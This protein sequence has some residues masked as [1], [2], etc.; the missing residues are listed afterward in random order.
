MSD[1]DRA[2]EYC[3]KI[4]ARVDNWARGEGY[5]P[6]AWGIEAA[7]RDAIF[8]LHHVADLEDE[9]AD[10]TVEAQQKAAWEGLHHALLKEIEAN[11]PRKIQTFGEGFKVGTIVIDSDGDAWQV[12]K[13][14]IWEVVG[15]ACDRRL[16]LDP[17]WGPYTIV[18]TPKEES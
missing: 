14:R 10:L 5:G 13:D 1:T 4:R 15:G 6:S 18:Y 9:I 12:T 8:L 17:K 16:T 3:E 2:R 11:R 7:E